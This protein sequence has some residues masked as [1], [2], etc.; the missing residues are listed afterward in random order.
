MIARLK[1]IAERLGAAADT[2]E[3]AGNRLVVDWA[4]RYGNPSIRSVLDEITAALESTGLPVLGVLP[5]V[6]LTDTA[7]RLFRE[8]AVTVA[9]AVA[10]ETQWEYSALPSAAWT[11]AC[12]LSMF[13]SACVRSPAMTM[14]TG[15][16]A[17]TVSNPSSI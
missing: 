11:I 15:Q 4:M 2:G 16:E 10:M 1:G 14:G 5:L 7:G 9:A 17:V 12:T 8:L 3:K 6:F 13:W